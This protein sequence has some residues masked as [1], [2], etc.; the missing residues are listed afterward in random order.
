[1]TSGRKL[2]VTIVTLL[3]AC[4][5]I[6]AWLILSA[7]R[8]IRVTYQGTCSDPETGSLGVFEVVNNTGA[9]MIAGHG[10]FERRLGRR[11]VHG[12]GDYGVDL[13]GPR[14][15]AP[16]STNTLRVWIPTNGGPYRL[17]LQCW[18][19]LPNGASRSGYLRSKLVQ[20][21]RWLRAPQRLQGRVVG[22]NYPVSQGFMGQDGPASGSQPIRADTNRTSS[23]AGSRS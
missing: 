19:E 1:M 10:V 13:G 23:A 15:F 16:G 5:A 7:P 3:V 21:M 12:L 14:T 11:W 9:T 17:V 6:V 22:N 4:F 20:M 8:N 18:P 2:T